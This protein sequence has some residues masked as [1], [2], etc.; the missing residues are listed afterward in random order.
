MRHVILTCKNHPN[1]R[2][3]CKEIAF[4]DEGGYNGSRN[5]MYKGVPNEQGMYG[6]SSGLSCTVV[7]DGKMIEEC[8]CPIKDLIRAEEDKLVKY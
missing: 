4:D 2:W 1:L 3:S 5:I 6:D 8:K 7:K